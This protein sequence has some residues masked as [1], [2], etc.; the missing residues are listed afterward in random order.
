MKCQRKVALLTVLLPLSVFSYFALRHRAQ[1]LALT[2][3]APILAAS[4]PHTAGSGAAM[5]S[6]TVAGAAVVLPNQLRYP[7]GA[8]QLAYLRIQPVENIPEPVTAALPARIVYDED[9]TARVGV[10]ITGRVLQIL[11]QPGQSVKR[12]DALLILDSPDYGNAR[13]DAAKAQAELAQKRLA[14]N[15]AQLLHEGGVLARKDLEAAQADFAQA[16]AEAMRTQLRFHNLDSS[17]RTASDEHYVLRAPIAGVIAER[18][19]NP[20]A[21][22]RPD[23]ST[24]L[25]V[26]TDPRQLWVM[27]DLPERDLGRVHA[28]QSVWLSVDAYPQIEFKAQVVS[29]GAVLDATS[30][31]VPLRCRV[32]NANVQL[33]PEMFAQASLLADSGRTVIRVPNSALVTS[34]LHYYAFTESSPGV[35]ERR[36]VTVSSQGHEHAI[37]VAGLAPGERIV[38]SGTLLLNAEWAGVKE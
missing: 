38:T 26:I 30:R 24:N 17:G 31:R 1:P 33:K 12:G 2:V 4:G 28:G 34:G 20:G 22:V 37:V 13:A 32:A 19:V 25:F 6:S 21:E 14:L 23:Q 16:Q 8:P 27:I 5:S 3:G 29:V 15:R 35:L 36:E 10:P 9:H 7:P 11:A 18:A